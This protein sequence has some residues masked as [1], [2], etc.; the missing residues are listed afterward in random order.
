MDEDEEIE[1]KPAIDNIPDEYFVGDNC[2]KIHVHLFSISNSE[3]KNKVDC[4]KETLPEDGY[5]LFDHSLK[6]DNCKDL[7][8]DSKDFFFEF[9]I[10]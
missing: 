8:N 4:F 6:S 9:C 1:V 7:L 5:I 3:A 2:T 10:I